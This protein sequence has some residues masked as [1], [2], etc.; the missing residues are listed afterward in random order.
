MSK[1]VI[2]SESNLDLISSIKNRTPITI[3]FRCLIIYFH[4]VINSWRSCISH[5]RL[6]CINSIITISK[7]DKTC[8]RYR[9]FFIAFRALH[10]VSTRENSSIFTLEV[11]KD[12]GFLSCTQ[13]CRV[14]NCNRVATYRVVTFVETFDSQI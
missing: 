11:S 14:V 5:I 8:I 10:I 9:N 3:C 13:R 4:S 7:S 2:T 12:L 1:I 6:N